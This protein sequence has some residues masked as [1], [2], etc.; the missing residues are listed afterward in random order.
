M[1]NSETK[2]RAGTGVPETE[3]SAADVKAA[4]A[5]F[6]TDITT[7]LSKQDERLTMLDR[8]NTQMRRPALSTTAEAE[9]PHRRAFAAY[10]RGGEDAG[11]RGLEIEGKAMSTAV[12]QI[13]DSFGP[14]PFR[15]VERNG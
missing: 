1:S 9:V 5:G 13:S 6:M 4:L 14:G 7:R 15:R 8:K 2:T 11:L 12:A 10:V 3:S